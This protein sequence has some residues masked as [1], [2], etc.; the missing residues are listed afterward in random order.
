MTRMVHLVCV[1]HE[2][3]ARVIT[4]RLGSDGI[5]T[6]VRPP[7]GG[8]YPLPGEVHLFVGEDDVQLARAL[9]SADEDHS[10]AGTDDG[11]ADGGGDGAGAGGA[12]LQPFLGT[13][14]RLALAILVLASVLM[15]ALSRAG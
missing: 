11:G 8:P 2:F 6:E 14:A 4:A 15:L 3:H 13:P 1:Q 10:S 5:F 12:A 9:L 7:L